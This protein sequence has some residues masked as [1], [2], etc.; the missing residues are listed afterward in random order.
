MIDKS[1]VCGVCLGIWTLHKQQALM[2]I[3]CL[4]S[5]VAHSSVSRNQLE[6]S[7]GKICMV[8]ADLSLPVK[9]S[10]CKKK[11][12]LYYITGNANWNP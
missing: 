2:C 4:F 3:H 11:L 1:L 8:F 12:D 7:Q 10:I 5:Y 9:I 6:Y